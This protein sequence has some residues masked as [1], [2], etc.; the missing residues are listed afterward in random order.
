MQPSTDGQGE[1]VHISRT[2]LSHKLFGG[3]LYC[4]IFGF[5]EIYDHEGR[6]HNVTIHPGDMVLFESHS[7]V[8]GHPFPLKGRYQALIFIHFEPTGHALGR[9]ESG[10]YY[11]RQGDGHHESDMEYPEQRSS[12]KKSNS[13]REIDRKHK[14]DTANGIGGQSSA[15]KDTLPPY[16]KRESPEEEH[17]RL[18]HPNGWVPVRF[19]CRFLVM[20]FVGYL[21]L[22]DCLDLPPQRNSTLFLYPTQPITLFTPPQK[23]NSL[24]HCYPPKLILPRKRV[25]W[26][27]WN[28]NYNFATNMTS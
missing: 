28:K 12:R 13:K 6:A 23:N 2:T 5:Q 19:C 9:N 24:R 26:M 14:E 22:T 3:I 11:L 15:T 4:F 20:F 17:W 16:I 21:A 25:V 7:V 10:Y 18:K 27:N 1:E 8:H